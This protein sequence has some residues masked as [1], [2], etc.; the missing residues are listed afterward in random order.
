MIV[1]Y[2]QQWGE[3][4]RLLVEGHAGRDTEGSLV[5]AAVSALTGALVEYAKS[6][7]A[8]R[9]LRTTSD[10]GRVFLSCR[11]GLENAFE[12]TVGALAQ[13]AAAY[14]QHIACHSIAGQ[15]ADAGTRDARAQNL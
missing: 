13:L 15:Y 12:M 7:P 5:C 2:A 3:K 4:Y 8:C 11:M 9:Y 6:S 1:V 10:K 14:P